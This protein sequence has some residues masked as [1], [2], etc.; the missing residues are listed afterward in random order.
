MFTKI[1]ASVVGLAVVLALGCGGGG[2]DEAVEGAASETREAAFSAGEVAE[3]TA[4]EAVT[5]VT[6]KAKD[7]LEKYKEESIAQVEQYQGE[8]NSLKE[9]AKAL[10]N[11]ELNNRVDG[12][13][14]KLDGCRRTIDGFKG[15]DPSDL[16]GHKAKLAS[17]MDDVKKEFTVASSKLTELK[18]K[19]P[20]L[21]G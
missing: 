3:G 6:E 16:E 4:R 13:Q 12:I 11:E 2:T 15:S 10:N 5:D 19:T 1:L 7:A 9:S 14:D 21:P 18:A 20:K 8:L 17:E